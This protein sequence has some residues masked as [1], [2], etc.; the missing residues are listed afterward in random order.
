MSQKKVLLA[1]ASGSVGSRV[2]RLLKKDDIYVRTLSRDPKRAQ[3]YLNMADE[4]RIA[5]ATKANSLKGICEDI[6]VVF[7]CLGAS[8]AMDL[9]H[10]KSYMAIDYQANKNILDEAKKAGVKRFVYMS[11]HVGESYAHTTYICAHEAFV[12]ELAIS[13]LNYTV[14]RPT[15]IY[16]SLEDFLSMAQWGLAPMIGNGKAVSNPVDPNDVAEISMQ[17]MWEGPIELSFGGPE[18]ISRKDMIVKAFE[19]RR[20]KPRIISVPPFIFRLSSFMLRFIHPRMS[21][22]LDFALHVCI[23]DTIAPKI[24]KRTLLDYYKGLVK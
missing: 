3:N 21:Q 14:L 4:T 16:T 11:A 18:I 5:D 22:L 1:G 24:G 6:D 13:G 2:L 8:V 17:Y 9:K 12:K 19:A 20:K 15:G 23:D 10:R 7:S